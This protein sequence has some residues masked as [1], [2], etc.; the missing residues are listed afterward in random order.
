MTVEVPKKASVTIDGVEYKN[1][2][3]DDYPLV[4][5]TWWKIKELSLVPIG[6]DAAAKFRA[7]LQGKTSSLPGQ[8][9]S[10]DPELQKKLND[11]L[12][13]NTNL[14]N[15]NQDLNIKLNERGTTMERNYRSNP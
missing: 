11:A 8:I 12:N 2:F 15:L 10:E 1:D 9:T 4:V 3:Q 5:R 13:E 14:K 6:A 7:E